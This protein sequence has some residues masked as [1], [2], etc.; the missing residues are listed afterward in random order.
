M[1]GNITG[2]GAHK[3]RVYTE[4][5][6][7]GNWVHLDSDHRRQRRRHQVRG[8]KG[9]ALPVIIHRRIVD[10]L[11]LLR[12]MSG[13]AAE[14]AGIVNRDGNSHAQLLSRTSQIPTPLSANLEL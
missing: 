7:M 1:G 13:L 12:A 8:G 14:T 9:L 11:I 5:A 4:R 6:E 3:G 10:E 2:L